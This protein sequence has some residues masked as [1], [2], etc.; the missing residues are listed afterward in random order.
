[1]KGVWQL[2]EAKSRFSELANQ[3]ICSG[4]QF[5]TKRGIESIVVLSLKEY[6]HLKKPKVDLVSFFKKV[7][8]HDLKVERSKDKDRVVEL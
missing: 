2:Q 8:L 5:V 3:A 4:P 6:K 1:M 7:P